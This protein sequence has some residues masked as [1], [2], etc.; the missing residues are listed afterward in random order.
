MPIPI[1]G[2]TAPVRVCDRCYNNPSSTLYGGDE[3]AERNGDVALKKELQSLAGTKEKG[4][5]NS[6]RSAVVDE[7]ASRIP[8]AL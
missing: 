4:P 8:V 6:R 2:I 7:L 1:I 3:C 5:V